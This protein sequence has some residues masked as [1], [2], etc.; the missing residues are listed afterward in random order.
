MG[1]ISPET[2]ER[3]GQL[4][5]FSIELAWR[6]QAMLV[7]WRSGRRTSAAGLETEDARRRGR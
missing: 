6:D 3:Y 5:P 1:N 4:V 7:T 2:I